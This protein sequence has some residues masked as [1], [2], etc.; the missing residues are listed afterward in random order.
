MKDENGHVTASPAAQEGV[1]ALRAA[2]LQK[3]AYQVGKRRLT[4]TPSDWFRA[5]ALAVRDRM[6]DGWMAGI[7]QAYRGQERRVYYLSLEFLVGRLL[8]DNLGALGLTEQVREAL[9][10]LDIDLDR[11]ASWMGVE[12]PHVFDDRQIVEVLWPLV[13]A[14]ARVAEPSPG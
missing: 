11:L 14:R 10:G 12:R 4:A 3:L 8:L 5:T 9:A 1:E 6:V 2:I 7:E 13:D